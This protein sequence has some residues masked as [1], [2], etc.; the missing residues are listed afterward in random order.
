[1]KKIFSKIEGVISELVFAAA[2]IMMG[3]MVVLVVW[4]M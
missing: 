3:L 2:S 1:M 4:G